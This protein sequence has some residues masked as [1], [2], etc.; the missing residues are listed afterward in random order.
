M[1]WLAWSGQRNAALAQF[2]RCRQLL[3]EAL[4]VEPLPETLALYEQIR[5]GKFGQAGDEAFRLQTNGRHASTDSPLASPLLPCP[6]HGLSFFHEEDTIFFFGREIFTRR[7]V[8]AVHK[9]SLVAVIGPSGSGK[10]SVVFAGLLPFLRREPNLWLIADFRPGRHPFQALAAALLSLLAPS[11]RQPPPPTDIHALAEQLD[12][13]QVSLVELVGRIRSDNPR[14]GP[15]LLVADQFEE[16]FTLCPQTEVRQQFMTL[17]L[18]TSQLPP[19]QFCLLFT[20]RADFLGQALVER[21]WSDALQNAD[22]KLGPMTRSELSQAIEHPA[23]RQGVIFETGL[24]ERILDNVGSEPGNL[25]LLEFALTLLWSHQTEGRLTHVAYE[26]IGRATGALARYADE[27]YH[28]LQP[29]DQERARQIFIQLVQPGTGPEGTR[30]VA[31]RPEIGEGNWPL[32]Q[33]LADARLIVTNQGVEGQET[34]EIVHETLIRNWDQLRGWMAAPR[35][36]RP[37]Q[38]RLRLP[39]RQWQASQRDEEALLRGVLLAEAEGWAKSRAAD[40]SEMEQEFV[41]ASLA[42]RDQRLKAQE[43]QL[44]REL[45]QAQALAKLERHRAETEAQA[46]RRLRWLVAALALVFILAFGLALFAFRQQQE[47]ERQSRRATSSQL[48]AQVE[49]VLDLYPQR[50]LLL[51]VEAL[52]ITLQANEPRLPAAEESLRQ[53]LANISGHGFSGHTAPIFSLAL[54]ADSHWLATGSADHT[55]RLWDLESPAAPPMVLTGHDD[56]VLAVAISPNHHWLATGSADHTVRLWDLE[57]PAATPA[58][59]NDHDD[60]V[61]AV[62][63]SPDS[64]WLATGSADHTARLWDLTDPL[65]HSIVLNGHDGAVQTVAIS[66]DNRWLAT[67]SADHSVRLWDLA[68]P[69]AEALVLN[70]HTEAVQMVTFSPDQRW[71]VSASADSTARL[72]D[73]ADPPGRP[74]VLKGHTS[75]LKAVAFS[76]DARWLATAGDWPDNTARLWDLTDPTTMPLILRGHTSSVSAVAFSPDSRW[77]ATGSGVNGDN[78]VRLWDLTTPAEAPLLLRGHDAHINALAISPNN[79]WL[80]SG[81]GDTTAR[82]WDLADPTRPPEPLTLKEHTESIL[83]LTFSPDQQ[84][85]VSGSG[86]STIRLQSLTTPA[87]APIILKGHDQQVNAIAVSSDSHWLLSGGQDGTA[88]LWDL[89]ELTTPPHVLTGHAGPIWAVAISA[90]NRRLATAGGDGTVRVWSLANLNAAPTVLGEHQEAV[91]AVTFSPDNRWLVSGGLDQTI[92]LW[93]LADLAAAPRVLTGHDLTVSAVAISPDNRWLASG[94]W[95]TT[96]RLWDFQDLSAAPAVLSGHDSGLSSVAFSPDS[97]SLASGSGDKTVRLWDLTDLTAPPV[98]LSGHDQTVSTVT[99]SPDNR[100]LASGS[101]DKTIRLWNLRLPELMTLA[102]QTANR[103]LTVEEWLQ[104]L[105]PQ[106]YQPSCLDPA[107]N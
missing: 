103:N 21:P 13:G 54:S 30:R 39:L 6:Y 28:Q 60:A 38:G 73:L 46:S 87:T 5:T 65:S 26:T 80:V 72:W 20:L 105:R 107:P 56:A 51:A 91:L 7:L 31:D 79:R 89:T 12:Q 64:H 62:A 37:W 32:V 57:S 9:Q 45:S 40:L 55:V 77:L 41:E 48:A 2:E 106:A 78:T 14:A 102:C 1:R 43:A 35:P 63:I 61:L 27:I 84:W 90:D 23:Q 24:V 29:T 8:E 36:F 15:I 69:T 17:L 70:G 49:T 34:A 44:Q 88:R 71:L 85:L 67:G 22:L 96:I 93:A 68:A 101:W 92:R 104:Y 74:V 82:L 4:E 10:S 75:S 99:F 58:V 81:S 94:S 33:R 76:P 53:A 25:P 3:T 66:P 86:D 16:L 42:V 59:L 95:D 18:E 98:I 47:A 83:G 19:S 97:R 100:R 50:S 52:N 11:H